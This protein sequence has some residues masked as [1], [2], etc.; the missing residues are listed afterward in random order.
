MLTGDFV[1]L[2]MCR[3]VSKQAQ[4][5]NKLDYNHVL[6]VLNYIF[7][8]HVSILFSNKSIQLRFPLQMS[9][10]HQGGMAGE[11]THHLSHP[12]HGDHTD[13]ILTGLDRTLTGHP[14]T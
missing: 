10:G 1:T 4:L 5:L 7:I 14:H 2:I 3:Y 12:T 13:W 6:T 11:G 9:K 8:K